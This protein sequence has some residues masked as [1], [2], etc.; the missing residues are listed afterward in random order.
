[1]LVVLALLGTL[2]TTVVQPPAASAEPASPET[3][4]GSVRSVATGY[5]HSCALLV[6]GQVQCWGDGSYGKLGNDHPTNA[7]SP[8]PVTVL[9]VTGAGPLT[10]VTQISLGYNHSCAL[11]ANHQVRCWGFN[12]S[13]Q[14]ATNTGYSSFKRAAVVLDETGTAPLQGVTAVDAGGDMTCALLTGG[15]VRC[16]GT[17]SYGG[18][19]DGTVFDRPL[20]RPVLAASGPGRL[21]GVTQ[22]ST[23]GYTTCARL[24][25]GQARCWGYNTDGQVG[26][27]T[28]TT[29]RRPR[30]VVNPAGTGPLT[31]V[32]QVSAG[33]SQTCA[34]LTSSQV[35][36]WGANAN[37]GLGIGTTV[38]HLRPVV[39][40]NDAGTG[41][42]SGV[43]RVESGQGSVCTRHNTGRV[44]CW[45]DG[46]FGVTG[47]GA[48]DPTNPL[49]ELVQ[50]PTATGSLSGVAQIQLSDRHACARLAN[51]GAV[52][53]GYGLSSNL[54]NGQ[55]V[56]SAVTVTVVA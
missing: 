38:G 52:C 39:V 54:G 2:A 7:P 37:G 17:N 32:R 43:T 4:L 6:S 10:G 42:L 14:L 53:W 24:G 33:Y 19:G 30:V 13:G 29:R 8:T 46:Q 31:R 26:D 20:P 35:R 25:N 1:M 27:G 36:C 21:T 16:W 51:G 12:D 55:S 11:L 50:N 15:Q 23:D 9:S 5:G 34:L 18:L 22:I 56:N 40:R 49:P 44:R 41:P 45:G 28:T 3:T 47:N 48:F